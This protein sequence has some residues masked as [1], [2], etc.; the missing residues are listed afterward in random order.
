MTRRH[1]KW[2]YHARRRRTHRSS[3]LTKTENTSVGGRGFG[4]RGPGPPLCSELL[5]TPLRRSSHSGHSRKFA[6]TEFSEVR[7]FLGALR[8]FCAMAHI[9][10]PQSRV[11]CLRYVTGRG[12]DTFLPSPLYRERRSLYETH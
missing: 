4:S 9:H 12:S 10:P 5:R 2:R 7:R 3:W 11:C 8:C 1:L 6:H